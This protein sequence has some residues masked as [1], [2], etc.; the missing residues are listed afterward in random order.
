MVAT[1]KEAT[2]HSKVEHITFKVV[3]SPPD[4]VHLFGTSVSLLYS[5][6]CNHNLAIFSFMINHRFFFGGGGRGVISIRLINAPVIGIY[7]KY[8]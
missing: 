7:A 1:K 8:I 2:E 6:Y 5:S 3:W 4:M